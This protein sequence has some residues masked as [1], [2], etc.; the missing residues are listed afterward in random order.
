MEE[1]DE[2]RIERLKKILYRRSKDV[3]EQKRFVLHTHDEEGKDSWGSSPAKDVSNAT[4]RDTRMPF[5]KK[6]FIASLGFFAVA[7]AVASVIFL[8]DTNTVSTKNVDILV[9]GPVSVQAGEEVQLELVIENNNIVALESVDLLVE[10][11]EGTRSVGN[12]EVEL[13]RF[14]KAIPNIKSGEVV[15]EPVRVVLFGQG[16]DEKKFKVALEYRVADS[17]AIFVK[18]KEY[19]AHIS[20][21]ATS[22]SVEIPSEVISGQEFVTSIAIAS[23]AET[24]TRDLLL[25]LEYP[26]GFSYL[27][28]EPKPIAGNAAWAIGDL[29]A[30]GK[31][32]I[33]IRGVMEGQDSEEKVFRASLGSRSVLEE[34][35]IKVVYNSSLSHIKIARPFLSMLL[36][37]NGVAAPE[38]VAESRELVDVSIVWTNNLPTKIVDAKIEAKLEGAVI[39]KQSVDPRNG[40]YNS[41]NNTIVWDKQSLPE[42]AAIESGAQGRTSFRFFPQPLFTTH[43]TPF[44]NPTVSITITTS[45]NRLSEAGVPEKIEGKVG[46]KIKISSEAVFTPNIVYFVGP[47][48]NTGPMPPQVERETTYTIVW[49]AVNSSNHI[50]RATAKVVLP[51][52]VRWI[53][54]HTPQ[55]EDI[56]FN[57][58]SREIIWNMGRLEAGTGMS[59]PPRE[60]AFQVGFLPSISQL[61]QSPTIMGQSVFSGVDEFTG[62]SLR[63]A[64][65]TLTIS[66][67]TDPQ[68]IFSHG[69]VVPPPS[70]E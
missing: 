7:I 3:P 34:E 55:G 16:G 4:P 50:S 58:T 68:F 32:T 63:L 17:N 40:F 30:K 37:V 56:S 22:L 66:L 26:F 14:R 36:F 28:A 67:N 29:A 33:V 12:L 21:S 38:Y 53:G 25:S 61:N 62:A 11:P 48:Q 5:W 31:R 51:P 35:K 1:R 70:P 10:Y 24:V 20:S 46:Q 23:N 57:E 59:L 65:R 27:S 19:V 2:G 41:A 13:D 6:F 49:T 45:G 60:V 64:G 42:L 39:D 54:A 18:E 69:K 8:R 47:F 52:Y 43:V 44:R 9:S 15:K